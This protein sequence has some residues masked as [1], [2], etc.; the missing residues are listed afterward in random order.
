MIGGR[1][2]LGGDTPRCGNCDAFL[3][4]KDVEVKLGFPQQGWCRAKPPQL[5][6]L[7]V[8]GQQPG[9][10]VPAYQGVFTPTASDVWCREWKSSKIVEVNNDWT[11]GHAANKSTA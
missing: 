3:R 5:V 11:P 8:P 6:Q 4:N 7:M 1:R 10:L 9:Q 2:D